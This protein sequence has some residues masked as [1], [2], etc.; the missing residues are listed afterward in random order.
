MILKNTDNTKNNQPNNFSLHS[1]VP[2]KKLQSS[3]KAS[4]GPKGNNDA[5]DVALPLPQQQQPKPNVL[6]RLFT[7]APN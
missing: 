6:A 7:S 2:N 3:V 4:F 1:P 5:M